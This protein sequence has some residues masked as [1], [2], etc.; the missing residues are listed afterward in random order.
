ML[1]YKYRDA[2]DIKFEGQKISNFER[3]LISIEKNYFWGTY[4]KDLNDP[5]EGL[6]ST[7]RFTSQSNSL[8]WLFG[9]KKTESFI[10][11][12]DALENLMKQ[13][14]KV[15]IYS[16]SKTY[17]NELL[18]AHYGNSHKGFCIEYDLELLTKNYKHNFSVIYNNKIPEIG[19][20]DIAIKSNDLIK[21]MFGYK[22]EKWIYEKEY[23]IITD[24]FGI[25][26][27]YYQSVKSIYFGL[28]MSL[29]QKNELMNRLKGRGIKYFQMIQL[30]KTYKFEA[31]AIDDINTNKVTYL[32]EIPKEITGGISINFKII[33][34][35]YWAIKGRGDVEIEIEKIIKENELL[36]LANEIKDN[37]FYNAE[38]VIMVHYIANKNK[39][40]AWATT[41]YQDGKINLNING[42]IE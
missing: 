29:N 30:P 20:E 1:V 28:N 13:L 22:Y 41:H 25:N 27:Y 17:N 32:K 6:I 39:D 15:G 31:E 21:K 37:L 26:N 7:D 11:V 24:D 34:Q 9:R 42:L 19:I 33:K 38:N 3:D 8:K 14:E 23:R 16:L 4:Y 40:M 36:W 2:I 5:C 12:K 10:K 18:W 35:N